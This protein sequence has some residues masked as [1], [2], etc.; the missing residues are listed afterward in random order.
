MGERQLVVFRLSEGE[1]GIDI[2][3]VKEIIRY[4]KT[5]KIPNAPKFVEGIIN[6]RS[7][8]VPIIDL[9][10][11]F[12]LAGKGIGDN[13]RIIIVNL[14]KR[15]VGFMVDEVEEVL[16]ISEENIESVSEIAV[17][18][19]RRFIKEI[20]KLDDRLIILLDLHKVLTEDEKEE[21]QEI[22]ETVQ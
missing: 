14:D 16:R 12:E 20:G 8:A 9:N 10:K 6:Y 21:L 5:V 22:P 17:D 18:I 15:Q 13:T 19:N 3:K 1:Y 4:Q 7:S 2:M 11:R